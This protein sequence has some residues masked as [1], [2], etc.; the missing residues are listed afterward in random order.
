MIATVVG[1]LFMTGVHFLSKALPTAAYGEFGVF[2][3]VS[4][5][6]QNLPFQ[7][8][9][10]QQTAQALALGRR[11]ELS[12]LI[13]VGW[14]GTFVVWLVVAIVALLFQDSILTRLKITDPLA[15]WLALPTLL[16]TAWAPMFLGILQGQQNFLWMGWSMMS[17][18]VGRVAFALFAVVIL[19]RHASGMVAGMLGGLTF[20]LVL[21][22]WP[23]RS[24]WLTPALPFDWR[25]VLRQIVPLG[26]GFAAYNFLFIVDTL[27]VRL[28][29]TT[30]DS[31]FYL[32]AGTM[33]RAAM[34]LVGPLAAVMFPKL[35]HA[36]AKAEKTNLLGLVLL[37]TLILSA[38]AAAGLSVL[39]FLP[40]KIMFPPE[41]LTP[42]TALLPWY[43][44]ALVPL[45]VGNVLLNHLLA[46]GQF[47]VVPGLCV[48]ALGYGIALS[49]FH[50]TPVM[51]IQVM[52]AAD[53][54]LT[55]VCAWYTWGPG[56][57]QG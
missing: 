31:S 7:I 43:G 33:A 15:L 10:A 48:V 16:F 45:S 55:A 24:L 6:I 27:V 17:N 22:V 46:H 49:Q 42:V 29:L 38:G 32:S 53:L 54:A 57:S 4:M 52:G 26:L 30:D 44:W 36:K 2:L 23:S 3:I 47:K 56:K 50:Q 51:V 35:V 34:W 13:R 41:Y 40:V 18:G 28:F 11:Q 25:A 12:G 8:V 1:G 39:G 37:G 14:I 21:A 19:H 20:S 9:L 5:F